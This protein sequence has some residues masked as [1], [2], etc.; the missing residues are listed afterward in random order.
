MTTQPRYQEGP[1]RLLV[2]DDDEYDRLAVRRCLR[3]PGVAVV[4]NEAATAAETLE[5][6]REAHYDC[7]LLDYYIPEVDGLSLLHDIRA[8]APDVPIVIFTGRGD[9]EVAVEIMKAGAVDYLPKASLTAERIA[10]SLR[11]AMELSR[12]AA[13]RRHA[14][15]ERERLLV[16]ERAS[17]AE[18]ERAIRARDEMLGVVAHDLRNPV[19]TIMMAAGTMLELPMD[20]EQRSRTL[21]I[22]QRAALTMDGL[23]RDLLDVTSL[24]LGSISIKRG[25]VAVDE[26][27][28]EALELFEPQAR[29]HDIAMSCDVAPGLPPAD[30]DHGRLTQVLSNIIGN[31]LKFTP[32]RGSIALR[33]HSTNGFIEISVED[34]GPGIPPDEVAR[35]FDRFW[36][37]DQTSN[38]GAGLGMTIAKG[39]VEAHGGRIW[40]DSV[41]GRGTTFRFIV[42][43]AT[44]EPANDE[45]A[46]GERPA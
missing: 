29:P 9:E 44:G 24:E 8:A 7:V 31:A 34:S 15:A 25:N 32:G 14:E 2:V 4:V 19:N 40:V 39:I 11:H 42:P 17:R 37:G 10:S 16:R 21:R 35:V 46:S 26:L 27:L 5:F 23:I 43:C 22:I 41:V 36:K 12:S 38:N 33:A 30:G 18:A 20:E 1:L 13:A 45:T 3:E 6:I 28:D